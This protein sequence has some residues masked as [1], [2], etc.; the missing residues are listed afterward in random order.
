M[1]YT[2]EVKAKLQELIKAMQGLMLKEPMDESMM[3]ATETSP[4]ASEMTDEESAMDQLPGEEEEP[5]D[6]AQSGR[7]IVALLSKNMYP[8]Y[9]RRGDQEA[10][11]TAE[12]GRSPMPPMMKRRKK[13]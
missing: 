9:N 11:Q 7:A 5:E 13:G 10:S 1:N 2:P 6:G 12:S 3:D 4:E 8:R